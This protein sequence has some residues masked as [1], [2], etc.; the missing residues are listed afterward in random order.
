MYIICFVLFELNTRELLSPK[1]MLQSDY[2][3]KVPLY[4][5]RK[6]FV[7]M[8]SKK[9]GEEEIIALMTNWASGHQIK[10]LYDPETGK[11]EPHVLMH[12][13]TP[14]LM[15]LGGE[16]VAVE[17]HKASVNLT[18]EQRMEVNMYFLCKYV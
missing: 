17:E 14:N 5:E 18:S 6:I 7:G 12:S 15:S 10:Y 3:L 13:L 9:L 8:V 11:G 4:L 1:V 16:V 2:L